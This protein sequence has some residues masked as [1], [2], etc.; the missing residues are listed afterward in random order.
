MESM[1]RDLVVLSHLRWNWVWQRPQHLVSRFSAARAEYGARTWFVEEPMFEDVDSPALRT[2]EVGGVT[3]VWLAIPE[4]LS[5]PVPVI[6]GY[7]KHLGF[8]APAAKEYGELLLDLFEREGRPS[9]PHVFVYTPLALD[10]ARSLNPGVLIYDVMDDLSS[11]SKAA[12]GLG[13]AQR[14]LLAASDVVFTGGKSLHQSVVNEYRGEAHLFAS[15][16]DVAHYASS[17][18]RRAASGTRTR[19][20]G[21][22]GVIDERV[23]LDLLAGLAD[24]LPDWTIRVVG[25]VAKIE[26]ESL[27]RR[28]NLDYCGMAAYRALPA[29]MAGF[30]V[31]LMP[32]A[33][34]EATRSI[35]PTKTLEYLA[36]GL[37]VV[38]TRI[39]D[40]VAEYSEVVRFAATASEFA[41]ACAQVIDDSREERDRRALSIQASRD[42]GAIAAS[43][44]QLIDL[45]D[46]RRA[47]TRT[48]AEETGE[49]LPLYDDL[50]FANGAPTANS[51]ALT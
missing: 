30:D 48:E 10:A 35:S 24:A 34:N 11:F 2:K 36:A 29:I 9:E 18:Q 23:D 27:P 43:M 4:L 40:V 12:P 42:W 3:R 1:S 5:G 20:A 17:R 19:V 50:D 14:R 37:P 8:D 6:P 15:G 28:R 47:E 46:E 31:A 32:F 45:A 44:L 33:L 16:V 25:P 39:P 38:S 26:P 41:T 7:G 22:V 21:Y 51:E 49:S 13:L